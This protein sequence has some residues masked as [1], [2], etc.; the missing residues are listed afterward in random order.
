MFWL[1]L[2]SKRDFGVRLTNTSLAQRA[3]TAQLW[4]TPFFP[5][6]A[7]QGQDPSVPAFR[8]PFQDLGSS[9]HTAQWTQRIVMLQ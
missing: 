8:L 4:M 1:T 7:A 5:A 3:K 9:N 2:P 6:R